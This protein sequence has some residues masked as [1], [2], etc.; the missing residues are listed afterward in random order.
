MGV[1][2]GRAHLR[3]RLP[4]DEIRHRSG[5]DPTPD[6]SEGRCVD[7]Y[8]LA[9]GHVVHADGCHPQEAGS[10]DRSHFP[11]L[12]IVLQSSR[13]SF[14]EGDGVFEA[15]SDKGVCSWNVWTRSLSILIH[16]WPQGM[17]DTFYEI[18]WLWAAA[19]AIEK[20]R[21]SSRNRLCCILVM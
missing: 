7:V 21:M 10:Q 9:G 3:A 12:R 14:E 6:I 4:S 15:P 8:H 20:S 19:Q 13:L 2:R 17:Y 1:A 18:R 16:S 11:R 5:L